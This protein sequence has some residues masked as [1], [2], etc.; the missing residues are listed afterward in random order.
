[1][2]PVIRPFE[3]FSPNI[4]KH[5]VNYPHT[6]VMMW[7]LILLDCTFVISMSNLWF[8]SLFEFLLEFV[9]ILIAVVLYCYFKLTFLGTNKK[10]VEELTDKLTGYLAHAKVCRT[11]EGCLKCRCY[12]QLVYMKQWFD[13]QRAKL[14]KKSLQN[15]KTREVLRIKK[16]YRKVTSE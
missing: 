6:L 2:K 1:M 4:V 9:E 15:L 8:F 14:A 10:E 3:T 7:H 16:H 5:Y 11:A 12:Y 13:E